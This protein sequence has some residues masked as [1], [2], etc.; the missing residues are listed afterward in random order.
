MLSCCLLKEL[1]GSG[2]TN[3][4]SGERMTNKVHSCNTPFEMSVCQAFLPP[5]NHNYENVCPHSKFG[6]HFP[7]GYVHSLYLRS[8]T[9][10]SCMYTHK[11]YCTHEQ[12]S[13]AK[14]KFV[15]ALT[16]VEQIDE[17][18]S[19]SGKEVSHLHSQENVLELFMHGSPSVTLP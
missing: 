17:L 6:L 11:K 7:K 15:R 12:I 14:R 16:W 8:D 1:G 18:P 5:K 9:M 13:R 10:D 2:S 3:N 19:A 4:S